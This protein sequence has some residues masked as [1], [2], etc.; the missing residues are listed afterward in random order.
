MTGVKENYAALNR[1]ALHWLKEAKADVDPYYLHLLTLA[2][3]GL[4]NGAEGD[5][6]ERNRYALREQVNILFGWKPAEVMDWLL[7]NP[8]MPDK[9]EQRE[10]LMLLLQTTT[11]PVSAAAHVLSTIYSRQVA[12]CP[13]LRS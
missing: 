9:S 13:A 11:E 12:A 6:P 5:W 4:E 3:W 10:S 1:A 8:N 2:D 7:S